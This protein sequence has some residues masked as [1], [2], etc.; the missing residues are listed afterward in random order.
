MLLAVA[1][2]RVAEL[3]VSRRHVAA[4]LRGGGREVGAEHYPALVLL[5]VGLLGGAWLE[6]SRERRPFKPAL[7]WPMLAAVVGAQTLRWWCV[8]TLG[9]QWTTRVIVDP[10]RPLIRRGPYRWLKHP[11]YV[12]VVL[13][14]AALPLVHTAWL[15]SAG[16]TSVNAYLLR[17]RIKVENAALETVSAGR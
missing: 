4:L 10:G 14:G 7:G 3:V 15:T 11:N 2:E 16:F 1:C 12:A 5:H 6:T 9:E 8:A 17:L 13:E